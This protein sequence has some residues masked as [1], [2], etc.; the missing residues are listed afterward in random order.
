M[1]EESISVRYDGLAGED[2][3]ALLLGRSVGWL[4][5]VHRGRPDWIVNERTR[6]LDNAQ[7]SAWPLARSAVLH[8][9]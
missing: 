4:L 2:Y 1:Y 9:K 6:R 5:A 8:T 7:K 3:V